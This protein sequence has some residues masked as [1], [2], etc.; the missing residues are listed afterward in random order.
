MSHSITAFL[1]QRIIARGSR[2]EVTRTI[3]ERYPG[4]HDAVRVFEDESGRV[5]DLDYWDAAATQV[6]ARGRGRPKLGV[7]ARE[8]TLLPRQWEWL[9]RQKGGASATLRRLVD[10]ASTE[11]PSPEAR[12]D[13]AYRFMSDMCGDRPGYEEALRAL[14][15]GESGRMQAL[16]AEWPEDVRGYIAELLGEGGESAE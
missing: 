1:D 8:I 10:A 16:I 15:R 12:R 14:Y 7:V 4:D 5:T 3:E 2:Q 13:A 11:P 6:E 9:S